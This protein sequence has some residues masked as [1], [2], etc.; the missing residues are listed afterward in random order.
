MKL[1]NLKNILK[2]MYKKTL[3]DFMQS[4]NQKCKIIYL[5][6]R[7]RHWNKWAVARSIIQAKS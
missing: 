4:E 7:F 6:N 2:Y 5:G 1:N 3:L